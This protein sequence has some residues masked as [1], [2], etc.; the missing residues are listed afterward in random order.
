MKC[1]RARIAFVGLAILILG[2]AFSSAQAANIRNAQAFGPRRGPVEQT[3]GN[4]GAQ[5]RWWNSQRMIDQLKL[6]DDQRKAMDQ[7]FYD[8]RAK[9]IDLQATLQKAELAMQPLMSADK[10]DQK[11]MEAQIDK[12]VA[13]RGDLERANARFLL[14][15]R[16]KLTSDQWKQLRDMRANNMMGP[17][18][19]G[20]QGPQ[21][22]GDMRNRRDDRRMPPPPP[23]GG[24]PSTAPA[25]PAGAGP[26]AGME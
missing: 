2:S 25:P 5:G 14:D 17:G 21:G 8:H 11:A 19:P 3:L 20:G 23:P 16:M 9:L 1:V 24:G 7:I 26:G 22:P 4:Q 6:T 13:A 18:G 12:V 10:P 15:I